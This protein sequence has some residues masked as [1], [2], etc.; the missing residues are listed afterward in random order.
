MHRRLKLDTK[1]LAI[2]MAVVAAAGMTL[3][4]ATYTGTS[5]ILELSTAMF[6]I[7]LAGMTAIL[8]SRLVWS[9]A[10]RLK[11]DGNRR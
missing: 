8:A 11:K 7:I 10:S 6:V 9:L 2:M 5:Q 4:A 1:T 3:A